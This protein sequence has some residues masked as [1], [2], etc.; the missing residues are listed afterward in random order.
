MDNVL[1]RTD[2]GEYDKA[3]QYMQ[4]QNK[5]LTYKRQL[6]SIPEATKQVQ[7]QKQ[8]SATP[9]VNKT[10]PMQVP[11]TPMSTSSPLT[12]VAAT[13]TL[14]PS[15]L[16]PPPTVELMS[17]PK[18]RKRPR[19]QLKIY[20]DEDAQKTYGPFR[21]SRQKEEVT[22]TRSRSS[23]KSN[24]S[25]RSSTSGTSSSKETLISVKAKRAALE[26]KIKYSDAIEE[27]Q[28][29]LNR[30]KLHQELSETLAEEAVYE[31][32]LKEEHPFEELPHETENMIDRFMTQPEIEPNPLAPA[33]SLLSTTAANTGKLTTCQ[34]SKFPDAVNPTAP[35][36]PTFLLIQTTQQLPSRL[37]PPKQAL[38]Y[39]PTRAIPNY[40]RD[41]RYSPVHCS[42][43]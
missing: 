26:Q 7:E 32:A 1:S 37:Y 21:R 31:E 20:L 35:Q 33:T 8:I 42:R 25:E 13:P 17:P 38:Q 27:Q 23:R 22:S 19:I 28:K 12:T 3:R 24:R 2:L 9:L 30:L 5:F 16:T 39:F 43:C 34:P 4:L 10:T 29:V 36:L 6:D 40:K 41:L 14:V 11:V 15:A 18:K